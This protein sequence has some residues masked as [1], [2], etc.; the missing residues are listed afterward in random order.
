M[1]EIALANG[2]GVVMVDDADFDWL[3]KLSWHI[4][5]SKNICYARTGMKVD[6]KY[7]NVHM[8]RLIMGNPD[9]L[10]VDH[11]DGN[12]LN[13]QRC[14]LRTCTRSQNMA[15]RRKV[16]CESG[17]KGVHRNGKKWKAKIVVNYVAHSLGTYELPEDAA[18]AYDQAARKHFGE[19]ANTNFAL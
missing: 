11:I 8:Q 1:K 2:N 15:N 19:F 7:R 17:Y 5:H 14:N 12:G 18:K 6:G 10:E 4:H 9:G 3:N 16:E 13:N